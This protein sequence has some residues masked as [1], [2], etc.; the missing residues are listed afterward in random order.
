MRL[1]TILHE[2]QD[3]IQKIGCSYYVPRPFHTL[4]T[5]GD[6]Q[7]LCSLDKQA[8]PGCFAAASC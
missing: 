7:N 2:V 5:P 8:G 6:K 3:I 1:R 4:H